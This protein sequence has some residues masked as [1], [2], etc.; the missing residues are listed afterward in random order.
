[1]LICAAPTH[2]VDDVGQKGEVMIVTS[3][4]FATFAKVASMDFSWLANVPLV[5]LKTI[6]STSPDF[7]LNPDWS[8]VRACTEFVPGKLKVFE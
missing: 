1:L 8:R 2:D 7:A 4:S 6:W 3:G 5:T